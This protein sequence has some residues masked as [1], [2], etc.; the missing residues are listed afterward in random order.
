MEWNGMIRHDYGE[1]IDLNGQLGWCVDS[2]RHL[3]KKNVNQLTQ[4]TIR[5]AWPN[6]NHIQQLCGKTYARKWQLK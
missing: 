1:T 6:V 3:Q 4:N 5:Q 2:I